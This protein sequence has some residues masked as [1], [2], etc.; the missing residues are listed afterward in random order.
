MAVATDSALARSN[1]V[2]KQL[3]QYNTPHKDMDAQVC[4]M[5]YGRE[6]RVSKKVRT[7]A[8]QTKLVLD[9]VSLRLS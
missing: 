2:L 8:H 6:V 3:V 1:H 5:W 4:V 9:L 7:Q